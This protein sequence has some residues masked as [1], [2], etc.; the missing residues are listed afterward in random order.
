MTTPARTSISAFPRGHEFPPASFSVSAGRVAAYLRAIGDEGAYGG[1]VPP[2]AAV[3]L[4][5][6]AL[7]GQISLPE[8]SLH[9]GQEVQQLGVAR[10]D[11]ELSMTAR[12]AQRSERQGFVIS[13]IEF[14]IAGGAG[15]AVRART[16][17]M[18]PAASA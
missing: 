13:V 12:I 17:I 11:E 18:A 5:L 14:E 3:A 15:T 1:S 9:T 10:A 16:T 2:L 4:G 6:E 7:Q 8:G